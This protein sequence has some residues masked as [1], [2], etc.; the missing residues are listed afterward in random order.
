VSGFIGSASV[1]SRAA[2]RVRIESPVGSRFDGRVGVVVRT[3]GDTVFV[4]FG[5]DERP[6]PFGTCE[7][8]VIRAREGQ[9]EIRVTI[10]TARYRGYAGLTVRGYHRERLDWRPREVIFTKARS[11]AERIRDRIMAGEDVEIG[12]FEA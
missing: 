10:R 5:R 3:V 9:P 11:S 4:R 1:G 6:L 8:K 7:V 12:D 2:T